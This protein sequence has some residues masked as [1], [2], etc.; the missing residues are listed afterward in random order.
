MVHA[1]IQIA[2]LQLKLVESK[3][4]AAE[5]KDEFHKLRASTAADTTNLDQLYKINQLSVALATTKS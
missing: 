4:E 5:L 2:E 1:N 3:A